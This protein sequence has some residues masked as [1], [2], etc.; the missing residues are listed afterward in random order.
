MRKFSLFAFATVA[1]LTFAGASNATPLG[2]AGTVAAATNAAVA[3]EMTGA[4]EVRH[5]R[6][7]RH[8]GWHPRRHYGWRHRYYHRNYGYYHH[9]PHRGV[10]VYVR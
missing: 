8:Y 10:R 4:S 1:A 3:N 9:R 7:Y 6:Y 2:A 5:R